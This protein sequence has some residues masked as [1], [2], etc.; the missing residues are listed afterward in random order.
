MFTWIPIYSELAK[1]ILSYR[2]R[3]GE[4]INLLKELKTKGLPVIAIVDHHKQG[5]EIP[6]TAI[7]PFTFFACFNRGL[8]DE[9]RRAILAYLKM[10]FDLQSA[11]PTDFDG[12][13][14]VN[15]LSAWFFPW[16]SDLEPDD[17]PSLWALAEGV[18]NGSPEKLDPKLFERCLQIEAVGPAKLTMGMFWLNP[19]QYIAWDGN[20]RRLFKQEGIE[21][22][23][24]N[25]STYLRLI[26]D[27]N[28]RLGTDYPQISRTAWIAG[29]KQYLQDSLKSVL[30]LQGEWS[31]ENSQAMQ[32]R[33]E[34][35]RNGIP[36]LLKPLS[37]QYG[38]VIEG[39]DGTGRKTRV[40]WVRVYDPRNSPSATEG[41]YVV[42]LFAADG[43]AVF[44]S[45]NQGTTKFQNGSFVPI[46]PELLLSRVKDARAKLNGQDSDVA[47]L[48]QTIDLRDAGDLGRGYESGNAYAI[49]YEADKIPQDTTILAD[50]SR[51]LDLLKVQY[52]STPPSETGHSAYLLTWNPEKWNWKNLPE[53]AAQFRSSA[54]IVAG[55]NDTIWNVANKSVKPGDRLFLIR[56]GKEPKGI[57]GSG[58]SLSAPYQDAHFSGESGKTADYV[59]LKWDALL[60]PEH[61]KVLS[62]AEIQQNIP[63]IHW[64]TQSSGIL[65][66]L[67]AHSK[68]E[69]MWKSHL[70][71]LSQAAYTIDDAC[72]DLFLES[73][74]FAEM[75]ELAR[76]RKNI[77]LQGPPGVGKTFVAKR[78]AYALI[79]AKDHTRLEWVQF[80][81]SYSYEDFVLGFRP[82]GTGFELKP[83]IFYRFCQKA[84]KDSRT[85]VFVIDEINRG[86]LSR[87]FGE[88]LSLIEEDKRGELSVALAYGDANP[89]N[90]NESKIATKLT[91]PPNL[92]LLGL[93]NTADRS[94]AVVDYALRRRFAFIDLEP[95]FDDPKFDAALAAKGVSSTMRENI[96]NRVKVLN[97]QI[98]SDKRNLGRG[99]EIGHSFFCPTDTVQDEEQWLQSII[100]YE[101][102]P[103]LMEY[104]F[105][106]PDKAAR[107]LKRLLG[108]NPD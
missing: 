99:F 68:L 82:N 18:V 19:K 43:S 45:L 30:G 58:Q 59:E 37:E 26:K 42:Y 62:L 46:D 65:I 108:E 7:D 67:E 28:E 95:R 94:L 71:R 81:Q 49:K 38:M 80:H 102:K 33:G 2:N 85:H 47:G 41:W 105:D 6:L 63:E 77:V 55:E 20:N 101:I 10:K 44:L 89:E 57:M 16:Q 73:D 60:D 93:M 11:V 4:L 39:R 23:V 13:P 36:A 29:E 51:L 70:S 98:A 96:R 12:I 75:C 1:K 21:G 66:P 104:W 92:I 53:L 79:G 50:T 72:A 103:L 35:I 76:R 106:D 31:A 40:P 15:N 91:I 22:N 54:E 25:L 86:N 74:F 78:F 5:K 17:I 9:N 32:Q 8:T 56:L 100:K 97:S 34:L 61:D 90:S 88:V 69:K 87:I 84:S 107:E 3:Q 27:V 64:T 24:E 14:I 52:G 83:G 48:L